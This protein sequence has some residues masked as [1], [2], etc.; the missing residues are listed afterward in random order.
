MAK[1]EIPLKGGDEYDVFT[2]WREVMIWKSGQIAKVKKRFNRR[3]RR[4]IRRQLA[5]G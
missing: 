2:S 4:S 5:N 1:P 3:L